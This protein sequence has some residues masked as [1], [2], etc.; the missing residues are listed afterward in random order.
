MCGRSFAT[1]GGG[2]CLCVFLAS[3]A[4]VGTCVGGLNIII[5]L[6]TTKSPYAV[7]VCVNTQVVSL[8]LNVILLVGLGVVQAVVTYLVVLVAAP[9]KGSHFSTLWLS[10]FKYL[11]SAEY[12]SLL[13]QPIPSWLTHL[14]S[15]SLP[16]GL[17]GELFAA[18][19]SSPFSRL[20]MPRDLSGDM[21][22]S[23][24]VL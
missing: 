19:P 5:I 10:L 21:Y 1:A 22:V 18:N 15:G 9:F 14:A 2:A 4:L 13:S 17:C 8:Q 23:L 6:Q 12:L 7:V 20:H 16:L 3:A 24:P 11:P